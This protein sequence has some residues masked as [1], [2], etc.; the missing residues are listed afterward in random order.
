MG[1]GPVPCGVSLFREFGFGSL[2]RISEL[3]GGHLHFK[4]VVLPLL[5]RE[6]YNPEH[7][8]Q[9]VSIHLMAS[10]PLFLAARMSGQSLA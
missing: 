7:I 3:G 10:S 4:P 6:K 9:G 2:D 5:V 1:G 8:K